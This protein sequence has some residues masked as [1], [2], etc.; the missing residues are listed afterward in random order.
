MLSFSL[1]A[2][3]LSIASLSITGITSCSSCSSSLGTEKFT[4]SIVR[5]VSV[6][7]GRLGRAGSSTVGKGRLRRGGVGVGVGVGWGVGCVGVLTG[8]VLATVFTCFTIFASFATL[9]CSSNIS[10]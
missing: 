1:S 4:T 8:C 2:S 5:A 7:E 10:M 6:D 9:N 3:Y